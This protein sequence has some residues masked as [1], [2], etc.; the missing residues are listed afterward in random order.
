M[1][2]VTSMSFSEAWV[3]SA[4]PTAS[5]FDRE[6]SLLRLTPSSMES[7]AYAANR[8]ASPKSIAIDLPCQRSLS[9]AMLRSDGMAAP[10]SRLEAAI[11]AAQADHLRLS[12]GSQFRHPARRLGKPADAIKGQSQGDA[13]ADHF[14]YA[15]H[16]VTPS[17]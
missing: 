10:R 4:I 2:H 5:I 9:R 11:E 6:G 14:R 1:C 16:E 17:R 13:E 15:V 8:C 12:A 7:Q 3:W